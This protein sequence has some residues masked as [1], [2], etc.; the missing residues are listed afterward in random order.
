MKTDDL[1]AKSKSDTRT[2]TFD[3]NATKSD[4]QLFNRTEFDIS[5]GRD[6]KNRL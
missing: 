1:L 3:Q 4:E 2:P 5:P 6:C